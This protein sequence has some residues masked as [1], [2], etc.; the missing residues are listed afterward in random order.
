MLCFGFC[1]GILLITFI[2][3]QGFFLS[4]LCSPSKGVH[5]MLG[6]TIVSAGD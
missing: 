5:K 4:V 1:I 3:S 2:C 6:G